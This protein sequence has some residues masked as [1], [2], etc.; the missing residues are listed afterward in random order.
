MG[1]TVMTLLGLGG[2]AG[3]IFFAFW[4]SRSRKAGSGKTD[5]TDAHSTLGETQVA[6]GSNTGHWSIWG[7]PG[8]N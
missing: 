2:L 1:N 4:N 7:D 3:F 8:S 6:H 5:G